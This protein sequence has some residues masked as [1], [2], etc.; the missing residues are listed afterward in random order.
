VDTGAGAPPLTLC[1]RLPPDVNFPL[2]AY[3]AACCIDLPA[4][5]GRRPLSILKTKGG[6]SGVPPIAPFTHNI[7][8][9]VAAFA[10]TG[11]SEVRTAW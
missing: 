10:P 6:T 8:Q 7:D 4:F 5:I 3:L 2:V 9:A 1:L 11:S